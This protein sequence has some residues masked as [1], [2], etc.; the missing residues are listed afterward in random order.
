MPQFTSPQQ[1][2]D[3]L[4]PVLEESAKAALSVEVNRP[5]TATNAK[6][7]DT[8]DLPIKIRAIQISAENVTQNDEL[9]LMPK[10]SKYHAL[11]KIPSSRD[12]HEKLL[13][14]I[15]TGRSFDTNQP[16]RI[17]N[18][19]LDRIRRGYIFNCKRNLL[20]LQDD[21][22]L[23]DVWTWVEGAEEAV[24]N[25]SMVA[26]HLDLAYLGVHGIWNNDLGSQ[27][28]SRLIDP[29]YP[30]V[31]G[32][33]EWAKVLEDLNTKSGRVYD[34]TES[35]ETKRPH[36]RLMCL[37]IC[38]WGKSDDELEADLQKLEARGLHSK[39]AAWALF[40]RKGARAVKALQRGG[41]KLLFMGLALGLTLKTKQALTKDDWDYSTSDLSDIKDDPYL[42]AI[43]TVISTGDMKSICNETSL[44]LRDRV[45]VALHNLND[46]ELP[47]WLNRQTTE[48]ISS[49][50]IEGVVLTGISAPFVELLTR[51]IERFGDYQ[52]AT[53]LIH[54]AA[55]L[56]ITDY[57]IDQWRAEYQDL[58]NRNRLFVQ[59]CHYDV[60]STKL[61]RNR[62][63]ISVIKPKPRQ[64]TLR[65]THC[66]TAFA[67]DLDNT[68]MRPATR[69]NSLN[70]ERSALHSSKAHSG[71]C[72][73]K[74]GKHLPRCGICLLILG[75]PRSVKDI[76][77]GDGLS[78]LK[79]FMSFCMKC[80]HAFHADHARGWFKVHNECPVPE[81]HCA[82]N[83]DGGGMAGCEREDEG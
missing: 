35:V 74:C 7:G 80:D 68:S 56:Y 37:A 63:G 78:R 26:G 67:N 70:P 49:G 42:R 62:E 27:W 29:D 52:T 44:P 48:A 58:H 83:V 6:D 65:C 77:P 28:Q 10:K 9:D 14:C 17:E 41:S 75:M 54:F 82:C 76:V 51:Y 43:Y 13:S 50:D 25:G 19:M 46:T 59:R 31:P 73:P 24:A 11:D 20:V 71:I 3:I 34:A 32:E 79:N 47:N 36:H 5:L 81:C 8:K 22:W 12:R 60:G 40:E 1:A 61:S 38:G 64:V 16:D 57:R 21:P 30:E 45:G 2:Q 53:L 55:P 15:S 39:A 33:E 66:D 18:L 72:C 23:H 4:K 69:S